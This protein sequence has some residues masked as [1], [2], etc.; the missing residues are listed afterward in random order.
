MRW[1]CRLV[2]PPGGHILD[3]FGGSGSTGVAAKLEGFDVTLCEMNPD[4]IDIARARI[5]H[6]APGQEVEGG[7]DP[8]PAKWQ[9]VP[10]F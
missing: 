4:F 1:L 3:M 5:R 8:E 7:T 2:T 6:A 10:M 9:Q